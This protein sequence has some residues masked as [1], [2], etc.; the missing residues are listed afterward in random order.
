MEALEKEI[1]KVIA[2]SLGADETKISP[3]DTLDDLGADSVDFVEIIMRLEERFNIII[4]EDE[5]SDEPHVR[6][7]ISIVGKKVNNDGY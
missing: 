3:D 7:V 6:E 1:V 4:G 5:F 2:E